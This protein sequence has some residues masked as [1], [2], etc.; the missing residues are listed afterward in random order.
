M[1][2]HVTPLARKD[3]RRA[4]RERLEALV[5]G[6]VDGHD[7]ALLTLAGDDVEGVLRF[8]SA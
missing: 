5:Q 1:A 8:K 7:S 2:E 3:V 6:W 4:L